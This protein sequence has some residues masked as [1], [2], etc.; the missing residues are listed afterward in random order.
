VP[1]VAELVSASIAAWD[2]DLE[3]VLFGTTAG[4]EVA[5][6]IEQ[7][8]ADHLSPV[9]E[10]I[11]YRSG[12]GSV[13]GVRLHDGRQVVIKV[14][15]WNVSIDRLMDVQRVQEHLADRSVPAPRPIGRPQPL[16]EGIATVE[17]H[18]PATAGGGAAP[19][20][21]RTIAAGLHEFVLAAA[22][23]V[24]R[25]D[26]GR[27]LLLRPAGAALWPEPHDL[28]FDFAATAAGAG[29]IDELAESSRTRL[30]VAGIPTVIGHFDW[31]V[32]NLGFDDRGRLVAIYDWDSLGEAP[33]PV[34]VGA[35]A[36]AF[37][38]DWGAGS[39]DQLPGLDD[40][41]GFVADY[42]RARGRA[43]SPVERSLLDAANLFTVA[44]GARCQHSDRTLHAELAGPPDGGWVRLLRERGA[45]GLNR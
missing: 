4:P 28:R 3:T 16:G 24:G 2:G 25:V 7:F 30:D 8:C 19:G 20:I 37:C 15:R 27:P 23:L 5:A 35:T 10:G 40:M 1:T 43:F 41:R 9:A 26:V 45:D 42:E 11:F 18:R 33:E 6:C 29:W 12:V 39:A 22:D 36:A 17:E 38:T 34:V 44:Y 31:R 32:E 13:V 14:H 21:R